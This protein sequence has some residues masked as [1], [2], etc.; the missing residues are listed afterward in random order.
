MEH[1]KYFIFLLPLLLIAP[2]NYF[3]K[4]Y[5][6][7]EEINIVSLSPRE[8]AIT[9]LVFLVGTLSLIL[10]FSNFSVLINHYSFLLAIGVIFIIS[11][12]LI[13]IFYSLLAEMQQKLSYTFFI[14]QNFLLAICLIIF[15]ELSFLRWIIETVPDF[16]QQFNIFLVYYSVL[17]FIMA[18]LISNFSSKVL[19]IRLFFLTFIDIFI[20]IISSLIILPIVKLIKDFGLITFGV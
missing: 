15:T 11:F 16:H 17:L 13:S 12:F 6:Q 14:K 10:H 8:T 7:L 3:L 19:N 2:H 18:L 1:Y 20:I 9:Y 5:V 4:K